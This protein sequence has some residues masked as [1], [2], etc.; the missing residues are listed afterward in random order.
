MTTALRERLGAG[1]SLT[2]LALRWISWSHQRRIYRE[3]TRLES[4]E[5]RLLADLLEGETVQGSRHRAPIREQQEEIEHWL[6]RAARLVERAGQVTSK[7]QARRLLEDEIEQAR[8]IGLT[9]R[10]ARAARWLS[11]GAAGPP[12]REDRT[13]A[14]SSDR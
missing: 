6:E 14:W 12:R 8:R 10:L 7:E 1:F 2:A 9:V 5:Y 13:A 4:L 11:P 3:L